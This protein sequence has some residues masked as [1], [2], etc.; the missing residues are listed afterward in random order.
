M[1]FTSWLFQPEPEWKE[2]VKYCDDYVIEETGVENKEELLRI[3][4]VLE[5]HNIL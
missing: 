3:L 1:S 5:R 2:R 4:E